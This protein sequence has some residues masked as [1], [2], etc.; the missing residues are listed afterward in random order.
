MRGSFSKTAQAAGLQLS[1]Q[2]S[3]RV[4]LSFIG[5]LDT[6]YARSSWYRRHRP[7]SSTDI[8]SPPLQLHLRL[9]VNFVAKKQLNQN[10]LLILIAG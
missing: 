2:P 4:N 9:P 7:G 1:Q 6:F 10:P 5:I 8:P 3:E